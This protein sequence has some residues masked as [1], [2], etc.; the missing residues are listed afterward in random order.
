MRLGLLQFGE[1]GRQLIDQP[2]LRAGVVQRIE[3]RLA[4]EILGDELHQ[5]LL[6]AEQPM[7]QGDLVAT[8]FEAGVLAARV[9]EHA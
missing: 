2:L 5:R 6:Y 3:A 7:A 8:A 9:F 4:N 1:P